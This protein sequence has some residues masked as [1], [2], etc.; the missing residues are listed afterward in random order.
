MDFRW[1]EQTSDPSGHYQFLELSNIWESI[2]SSWWISRKPLGKGRA[3]GR[4][5]TGHKRN[6]SGSSLTRWSG[7]RHWYCWP[8]W[9]WKVNVSGSPPGGLISISRGRGLLVESRCGYALENPRF[10]F[11]W[12][13][14]D[15]CG[16]EAASDTQKHRK[17]HLF[18]CSVQNFEWI[19]ISSPG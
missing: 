9:H 16:L 3:I 18:M 6:G 2:R 1:A 12:L 13:D 7:G 8:I 14:Q 4:R 10:L 15:I 5:L 17:P 19:N 11:L